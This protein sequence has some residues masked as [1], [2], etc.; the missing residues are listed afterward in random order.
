MKHFVLK[1]GG[2]GVCSG[3]GHLRGI[4]LLKNLWL[5]RGIGRRGGQGRG[6]AACAGQHK[7]RPIPSAAGF[8]ETSCNSPPPHAKPFDKPYRLRPI[9][10]HVIPAPDANRNTDPHVRIPPQHHTPRAAL[11]SARR[12]A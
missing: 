8:L 9:T 5:V 10:K 6:I 1:D 4:K 12:P 11:R 7:T 2:R 3:L